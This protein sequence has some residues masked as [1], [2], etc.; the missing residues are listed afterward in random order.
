[1]S[2]EY[3]RQ[4]ALGVDDK[5]LDKRI[6]MV[7]AGGLGSPTLIG[8]VKTGFARVDV[9][10]DDVV[11]EHNLPTQLFVQADLGRHKSTALVTTG[12]LFMG[13]ERTQELVSVPKRIEH[14]DQMKERLLKHKSDILVLTVDNNETRMQALVG[15]KDAREAGG[16]CRFLVDARLNGFQ[17][18]VYNV[19]L[20]DNDQVLAYLKGLEVKDGSKPVC[21]QPATFG[22]GMMVA[23]R[24]VTEVLK[25]AMLEE[26][27]PAQPRFNVWE[28]SY[29]NITSTESE[30]F[31]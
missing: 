31:E 28:D 19:D 29:N 25:D 1:M 3:S 23:G 18:T 12:M 21:V 16:K 15:A 13:K 17:S 24:V 10:D 27:T 30:L 5:V 8:L 6:T 14:A 4:E 20:D 2:E 26:G 22:V 7:G 11:E 9:I